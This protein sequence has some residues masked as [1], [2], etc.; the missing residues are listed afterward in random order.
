M[1]EKKSVDKPKFFSLRD[2]TVE[3]IERLI[4]VHSIQEIE[5]ESRNNEGWQIV[6]YVE[7]PR[8]YMT[9]NLY[10]PTPER[11]I[12]VGK[13]ESYDSAKE[14]LQKYI[15]ITDFDAPTISTAK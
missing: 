13:F 2:I 6:F 11:Y 3:H 15:E 7:Y 4:P 1:T 8:R 10:T 14:F 12:E 5:I 9:D